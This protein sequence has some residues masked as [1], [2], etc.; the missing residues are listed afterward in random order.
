MNKPASSL[1]ILLVSCF[2]MVVIGPGAIYAAVPAGQ[3]PQATG[4]I[5]GTWSGSFFSNHSDVPAFSVTIVI[6]P[7]SQGHLTGNSTLNSHCL[8]GAKVHLTV[9]GSQVVMAGSDQEGDN[10][11]VRGKLDATGTMLE[12]SYILNGSATGNCETDDGPAL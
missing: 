10:M 6:T 7:D 4:S 5:Q 11:T 2:V 1:R 3:R 8:K 12:S 9:S